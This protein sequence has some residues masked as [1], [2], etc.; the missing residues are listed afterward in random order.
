MSS[1]LQRGRHVPT[2]PSPLPSFY[3]L[4]ALVALVGIALIVA[5][6][7]GSSQPAPRTDTAVSIHPL[8]AT[9]GRTTD[10]FAYKGN[11]NAPVKVIEYADFQCPAC[12]TFFALQES[13]IDQQY[14]ETGKVQLIFHDFPLPQHANAIKTGVAARCAGDQAAFWPMHDLLFSRQQQWEADTAIGPRLTGYATELG[15]DSAKFA[16]CMSA[17][18]YAPALADAAT[19]ASQAGI[20]RTPTFVIDGKPLLAP[21]LQTSIAAAL[22]AKGQ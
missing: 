10:G 19:L 7:H 3:V 6:T 2:Q 20:D 15:L 17:G 11:P 21:D 4:L 5:M 16:Q 14:I 1:R 13:T 8:Q 12:A 18:T 9:T 22:K